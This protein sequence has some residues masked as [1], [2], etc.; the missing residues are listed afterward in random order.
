[1]EWRVRLPGDVEE[2]VA[3]AADEEWV[4]VLKSPPREMW[5]VQFLQIMDVMYLYGK[6]P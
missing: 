5:D 1:M 2:W 4:G 6:K 3:V